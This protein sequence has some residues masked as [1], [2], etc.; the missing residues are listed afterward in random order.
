MRFTKMH[1]TGNDYVYVD[2]VREPQLSQQ[3]G[4]DPSALAVAISRPHVGIGADGLVL[5]ASSDV[6]DF[7]MRIF[8][9]D[10]SEAEMCG[11][12]SRCIGKYVYER[13]LTQKEE[14]TLETKA[15][16]RTVW[17]SVRGGSVNSVRVD[18]GEPRLHP[19]EIGVSLPGER[20]VQAPIEA[21]GRSWRMTCVSMGNPHAVVFVDHDP[22]TL[23]LETVGPAFERH[24]LFP[25]RI[26]TEFVQVVGRDALRMRVWERGSGETQACGTGACAALVASS[27]S[28][29][30]DRRATVH[31]L[32]GDLDIEWNPYTDR[33][34]LTGPAAFVF[35]GEWLGGT[36]GKS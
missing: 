20:V 16:V 34:F 33:V 32:G 12:A 3:L 2:C 31:L 29:L 23:D 24:P 26:N 10:G 11:N 9:A 18:M 4:P 17:L 19:N 15:G 5:I 14:L 28:S 27:L 30:T 6:A 7:S 8:N 1:G 22:S 25:Q 21:A 13:G 36:Y 35:D